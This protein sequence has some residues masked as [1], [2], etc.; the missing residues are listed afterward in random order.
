MNTV[1]DAYGEL[2]KGIFDFIGSRSWD[3]AFCSC[4]IYCQMAS[5]AYWLESGGNVD[6][7][8]LG[9]PDTCLDSGRAALFIRDD[10]LK[11][12]GQRI[13][14]LIFT[15]YPDGKFNIEYDYTK[16]EGYEETDDLVGEI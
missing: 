5:T 10:I 8:A 16:P 1:E 4:Q 11:E 3:R 14:G 12:N 2:A 7:R 6:K 9:W 15:L 13:W